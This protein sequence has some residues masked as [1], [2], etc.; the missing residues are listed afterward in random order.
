MSEQQF[1]AWLDLYAEAFEAEDAD[2]AAHLFTPDA[3][4][5]WGPFGALLRGPEEIRARW[6]AALDRTGHATCDFE[7]LAV[8]EQLSIAR[9]LASY[10]YPAEQRR[11]RYDGVFAVHLTPAGLCSDFREW[12]NTREDIL[13]PGVDDDGSD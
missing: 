11:V 13:V 5:Q 4:Y 7:I 10:T 8:T 3:T 1:R 2:A 9:W 12:W 6:A